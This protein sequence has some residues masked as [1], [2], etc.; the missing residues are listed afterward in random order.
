LSEKCQRTSRQVRAMSALPS[1]RYWLAFNQ[2]HPI[3]AALVL[4]SLWAILF[5]LN[6]Q[7]GVM[8]KISGSCLCG[9][10]RYECNAEPLGTAIC[11]CTH[12]QKVS[13][14]AFSVNIVVPAPSVNWQGQS[15]ASYTDKGESGKS[16]SRKFCRNCGSSLATEAEA[17]PG[18]II[19]KAG[20]LDDKSWIKPNTHIWT[21]SAQPWVRI[22]PGATTFL[23]GRT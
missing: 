14:S 18:A 16:L 3:K 15:P 9:A 4:A 13:G 19:I 2:F 6:S 21:Q 12:C 8:P 23:K 1:S 22:E 20:T 5:T 7:E 10:V 17:L 11:H